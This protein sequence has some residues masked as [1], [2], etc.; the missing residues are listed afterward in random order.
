MSIDRVKLYEVPEI[1]PRS[2]DEAASETT[3]AV[4][5]DQAVPKVE[6]AV[7]PKKKVTTARAPAQSQHPIPKSGKTQ[8]GVDV[9]TDLLWRLKSRAVDERRTVRELVIEAL[10][11]KLDC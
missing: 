1:A 2:F 7:P 6:L 8:L 11:E 5:A 3:P 9:P 10:Y 4:A